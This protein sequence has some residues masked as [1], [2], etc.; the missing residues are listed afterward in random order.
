MC[1]RISAIA[2][3]VA[4]LS[5]CSLLNHGTN[6]YGCKGVPEGVTCMSARDMYAATHNGVVVYSKNQELKCTQ[7]SRL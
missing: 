5:G 1:A 4:V 6:E 2:A 3:A 7:K